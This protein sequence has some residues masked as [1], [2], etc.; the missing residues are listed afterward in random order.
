M[1]VRT[2]LHVSHYGFLCPV[3]TPEGPA[4][5]LIVHPEHTKW[6]VGMMG[7]GVFSVCFDAAKAFSIGARVTHQPTTEEHRKHRQAVLDMVTQNEEG[8]DR[9][10]SATPVSVFYNGEILGRVTD[11]C[12]F[13]KRIQQ[14]SIGDGIHV[15]ASVVVTFDGI[16]YVSTDEGRVVRP[17]L[18]CK[19]WMTGARSPSDV[20]ALIESGAVQYVDAAECG[21]LDIALTPRML[22]DRIGG[23][24]LLEIHPSLMLSVTASCIPFIQCPECPTWCYVCVCHSDTATSHRAM[25]IKRQWGDRRWAL[26]CSPDHST[27]R[28]RCVTLSDHCARPPT[29][30]R[31]SIKLNVNPPWGKTSSWL[32]VRMAVAIK[33]VPFE[34]SSN[35]CISKTGKK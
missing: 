10:S 1:D 7:G 32:C 28:P 16:L 25:R 13:A 2:E 23:C 5:G 33:F 29:R 20:D 4:C 34:V 22:A 21:V 31:F 24:D 3:E 27:C 8:Q 26:H 18:S 12:S 30:T 19:W 9:P 6:N 11:A 35:R 15:M 17:L 14:L